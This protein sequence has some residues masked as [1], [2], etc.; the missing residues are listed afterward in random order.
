MLDRVGEDMRSK[1]M[2]S[3]K[4]LEE[5]PLSGKALAGP[6]K[7]FYSIRVWPFR[8]V[9]Q[10]AKGQLIVYVISIGHRKEVYK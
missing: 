7:G 3:M 9:Y 2:E 8:I 1:L 10:I 4:S 5:D 6:L